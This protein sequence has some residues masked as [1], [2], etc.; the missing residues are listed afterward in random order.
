MD[1]FI[2]LF[3]V[4]AFIFLLV[5]LA[6]GKLETVKLSDTSRPHIG[7]SDRNKLKI[8]GFMT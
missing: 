6:V 7:D 3:F 4:I 8:D 5:I 2:D 1:E